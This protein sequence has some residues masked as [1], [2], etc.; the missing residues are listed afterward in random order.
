ML[1]GL[2]ELFGLGGNEAEVL[3]VIDKIEKI[4]GE[5]VKEELSTLGIDMKAAGELLELLTRKCPSA[6]TIES[7]RAMSGKSELLDEGVNELATVTEY[8]TG[9]G[10]PE[11]NFRI[12]LT[13]ARGLDYYTGTVYETMIN[14]HPEIGSVCSGGRYENLA[15]FYTNRKLPG[16]GISIG[17]TRL[18][19]VLNENG[20]LNEDRKY[21]SEVLV[22]PMGDDFKRAVEVSQYLRE[23]GI[24][25]QIYYEKKKFKARIGYADKLS[26]PFCIF[27]GEDEIKEGN[28]SLK[29]MT[30]GTQEKYSLEDCA[31]AIKKTLTGKVGQ[32]LVKSL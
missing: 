25:S 6:E 29:N 10:V 19:Y 24:S 2:F 27:I 1:G 26:I 17:L 3:R 15:G 30:D 5:A 21:P 20:W 18:F 4:G 16:V 12:D 7:L 28:V 8:L 32:A 23:Q 11:K 22:I 9:F 14:S 31:A 13:I